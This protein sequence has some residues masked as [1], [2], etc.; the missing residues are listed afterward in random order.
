MLNSFLTVGQQVVYLFILVL[1]GY[2]LGRVKLVD[3]RVS[4][5]LSELVLYVVGPA[6]TIVSFQRPRDAE[7]F[8]NFCL[9]IV[10]AAAIHLVSIALAHLIVR[11]PDDQ[12]RR[13]FRFS[14]VMSNC[15]FLGYPLEQAI[16]GPI[17]I[18]YGS[19]Y[20][21]V[22]SVVVWTY[23]LRLI[24]GAKGRFPARKLLLNPGILGVTAAL[25]LYLAEIR[26]PDLLLTPLTYLSSLNT[27]VPMLVVGYQLSRVDFRA[28]LGSRSFWVASA[29]RLLA[30]PAAALALGLALGLEQ[31]VLIVVVIAASTPAAAMLSMMA[32]KYSSEKALPAAVVAAET[33]LSVLTMPVIV[34][35][36]MALAK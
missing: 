22:F 9:T 3:D 33:V 20:T 36:A 5:G 18:F 1:V 21:T 32:D 35:L 13:I 8:R 27:P 24:S 11:D 4:L 15:G 6:M 25:I 19:A 10:A 7:G 17:G 31:T 28:V 30:V 14:V 2:V 12:K 29:L 23:G 26:L 34:G 16:L